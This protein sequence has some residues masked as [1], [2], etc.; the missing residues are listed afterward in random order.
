MVFRPVAAI[1][2]LSTAL[3]VSAGPTTA[4]AADP[5]CHRVAR[6]GPTAK[7]TVYFD[8]GKTTIAPHHREE[9]K[10]VAYDAKYQIKVC[11]IGQADQQGNAAFNQRLAL[12]RAQA[13]RSLL[14]DYGVPAGVLV[15]VSV[16]EAYGGFGSNHKQGQERRV[17]V[18]FPRRFD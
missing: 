17:E 9:L 13:V 8:T 3:L 5:D 11:L 2:L 18:H 7:A 14:I 15:A 16:G 1:A 4:H 12:Q 10:R 6:G